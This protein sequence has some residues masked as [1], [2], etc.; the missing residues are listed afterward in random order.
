MMNEENNNTNE[1]KKETVKTKIEFFL[2]EKIKC[3]ID[4]YDRSWLNGFFLKKFKGD[5]YEFQDD[6]LGSQHLTLDEIRDVNT[7]REPKKGGTFRA[8]NF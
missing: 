5:I 3:Q 7:F 2:K 4:K 8:N 1:N 6:V